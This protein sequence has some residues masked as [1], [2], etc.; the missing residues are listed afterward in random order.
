MAVTKELVFKDLSIPFNSHPASGKITVL[1][2]NDALSQALKNVIL[3]NNYERF[4]NP[5]FGGN[6]TAHLFENFSAVTT[7]ILKKTIEVA[8]KNFEPRIELLEVNVDSDIDNHQLNVTV[9]YRGVNQRQP[10]QA[11]IIIERTR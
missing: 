7:K 11:R 4:Y 5:T 3:T 10:S 8:V 1:T 6:I 2:N 9:F